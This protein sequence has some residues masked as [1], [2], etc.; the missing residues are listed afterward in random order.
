MVRVRVK[1]NRV[2]KD[3]KI[4]LQESAGMAIV[5]IHRPNYKNAMTQKMWQELAVIGREIPKNKKTRVVII[6]GTKGLFS[7]GSDIKEFAEM[8]IEQA[9]AAFDDMEDAISTFEKLPLPT[10]ALVNG[11]SIGAGFELALACDLRVG[12]PDTLMGIPVGGLGI[13][14]S[15]Q[16]VKRIVNI[17]GPSRAKDFVYTGRLL[18]DRESYE[19]GLLNYLLDEDENPSQFVLKL[20]EKIKQQSPAS[21]RAVKEGVAYA[22]PSYD[23]PLYSEFES[24][25]DPV[26]FPEGV[27]AFKEKRRPNFSHLK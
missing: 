17:V 3:G 7:S 20:A 16:F 25:V 9:N 27:L 10:I 13:T 14:L 6:R 23:I 22:L 24:R 2:E 26:D 21:L 12:T 11:P 8:T 15:K 4:T 5:T 18:N 19:W 1:I